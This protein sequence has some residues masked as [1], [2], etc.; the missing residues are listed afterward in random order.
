MKNFTLI[1]FLCS[2]IFSCSKVDSPNPNLKIFND[3]LTMINEVENSG[4]KLFKR[5]IEVFDDKKLNSVK[6]LVA[7]KAEKTLQSY[8]QSKFTLTLNEAFQQNTAKDSPNKTD[9]A[10]QKEDYSNAVFHVINNVNFKEEVKSYSIDVQPSKKSDMQKNA[11]INAYSYE[12]WWETPLHPV[13]ITVSWKPI[14]NSN[15]AIYYSMR[16]RTCGL[17]SWQNPPGESGTLDGVNITTAT[18]TKET[19]RLGTWVSHNWVN[20]SVT[21]V[22]Q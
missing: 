18:Y 9:E 19:R 11:K 5:E 10:E 1:L 3:E 14:T 8:L 17:C 13:S 15:N 20:Y 6:I 2:V 12:T 16:Y 4:T 7:A 21:H 22:L